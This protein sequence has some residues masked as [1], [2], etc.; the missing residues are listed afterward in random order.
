MCRFLGFWAFGLSSLKAGTTSCVV[1]NPSSRSPDSTRFGTRFSHTSP[2]LH[3]L[4]CV[5]SGNR[6]KVG[7]ALLAWEPD[8]QFRRI[9]QPGF[10][11]PA[12]WSTPSNTIISAVFPL[13]LPERRV[14]LSYFYLYS[15]FSY[16]PSLARLS[17]SLLSWPNKIHY[18]PQTHPSSKHAQE[19]RDATLFSTHT[20]PL[21]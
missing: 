18:Q 21:R 5:V 6:G 13:F 3:R 10:R 19:S 15:L 12:H 2:A 9:A 14:L 16:Y 11:K 4:I 17:A 20:E 8:F 1:N 7:A